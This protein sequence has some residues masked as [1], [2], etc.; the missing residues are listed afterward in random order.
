MNLLVIDDQTS[1]LEGISSGVHFDLLGF[2]EV[3]YADSAEKARE[4]LREHPVEIMLSDIE[5]PGENGLSLNRWTQENYPDILRILLTSHAEFSYA[6]ESIRLGCFDYILQPAPFDEIESVLRRAIDQINRNHVQRRLERKGQLYEA[7]EPDMMERIILNIYSPNSKTVDTSIKALQDIGFKISKEEIVSFSILDVYSYVDRSNQN[8]DDMAVRRAILKSLDAVEPALRPCTLISENR[9]HMF[10]ILITGAAELLVGHLKEIFGEIYLEICS[11]LGL[12]AG[13][14]V[15]SVGPLAQ[16]R[17]IGGHTLQCIQNNVTRTPGVYFV[18]GSEDRESVTL[19]L[20]E[21]LNRWKRM[22]EN[23]SFDALRESIFSYV[24]IKASMK[25]LSFNN[26]CEL[27]Q[28]LTQ[29]IFTY[30]YAQHTDI[31]TLFRGDYTYNE[32]MDAFESVDAMKRAVQH[33]LT[34]LMQQTMEESDLDDVDRVK[35]YIM[36]NISHNIMVRDVAEY[37]HR[38]PE[39]FTKVFKDAVGMSLKAY[40]TQMKINVA[41]DMLASPNIPV[42]LVAME[43]GYDNFSHFTQVFKKYENITPTEYRKKILSET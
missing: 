2:D 42:S 21:N 13:L 25:Q 39:Y 10:T 3:F 34:A 12:E 17:S 1:V 19:N 22:L 32:F 27:H 33:I 9:N 28:K 40:I 23:Q 41:K 30:A 37:V 11:K 29:L 26:L 43:T 31:M 16:I 14:Y 18:D 6:Q 38:S 4:I 35:Q 36:E 7:Y 5:M 15:S 20:E 24:D 8:Y